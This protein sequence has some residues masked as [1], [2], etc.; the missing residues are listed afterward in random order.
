VKR[1]K[2]EP[3][4]GVGRHFP[5]IYE[6]VRMVPAGRV[7][8]YGMV[9]ALTDR[10]TPRIVGYAMASIP[11]GSDVPW[12]RVINSQGRISLRAGADLQ[13]KMLEAEGVVFDELGRVD[14]KRFAWEGPGA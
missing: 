11:E 3:A 10:C 14:L 5:R 1:A 7:V 6:I 13:R 4:A 2:Y 12:H 8:S 9:A